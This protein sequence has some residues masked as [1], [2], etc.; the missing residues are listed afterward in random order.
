MFI[1]V[2][3]SLWML[4]ALSCSH[5]L[6]TLQNFDTQ[7]IFQGSLCEDT[8]KGPRTDYILCRYNLSVG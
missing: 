4:V 6:E 7:P 2:V 8:F 1:V 5:V 3:G